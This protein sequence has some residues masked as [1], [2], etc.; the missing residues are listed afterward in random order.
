M[1]RARRI[2]LIV[3]AA[4]ALA[5]AAPCVAQDYP[6]KGVV[7]IVVPYAAGGT[8]DQQGRMAAEFLTKG[9]GGTFVV[10]NRVGFGGNI[11]A[12]YVAKAAPDGYTLLLGGI[13]NNAINPALFKNLP[14]SA[15]NDFVAVAPLG[16]GPFVLV[17]SPTSP[18]QSLR[19]F[20]TAAKAK[21]GSIN[22]GSAGNGTGQ[23]LAMELFRNQAGL[24]LQHIPYK[25][26]PQAMADVMGGAVPVMFN[27]IDTVIPL[28][29]GGKLRA[30]GVSG[31]VRSS[32]L[33]D[34][35]TFVEQGFPDMVAYS[36]VGVY[37]PKGT[38]PAIV[39]SINRTITE[40]MNTPETKSKIAPKGLVSAPQTPEQFEQW[41]KQ[42]RERW[43]RLVKIS[44]AKVD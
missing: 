4:A 8:T 19:D 3:I 30:L 42:E 10:E 29:T 14:Y 43:A 26:T 27:N 1:S 12:D 13:A 21:P 25:G 40:A 38:P 31:A 22:Y 34:V 16:S 32:A 39:Q 11:G 17:T 35:P 24:D 37:A 7:T 36:W 9:L 15:E 44:G 2:S 41:T 18:Y 5:G 20:V 6:K 33:P 28:V 23:H